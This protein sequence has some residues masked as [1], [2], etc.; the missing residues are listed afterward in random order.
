MI[1]LLGAALI[2]QQ[3]LRS[4][5]SSYRSE[6]TE[7][8][9]KK[10]YYKLLNKKPMLIQVTE[11][12]SYNGIEEEDIMINASMIKKV[13]R[14]FQDF[15]PYTKDEWCQVCFFDDTDYMRVKM[16]ADELQQAIWKEQEILNKVK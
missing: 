2:Q 7:T 10:Q 6:Q 16:S 8:K 4:S 11:L 14:G 5:N 3:I 15:G 1:G 9:K 13:K 12:Q